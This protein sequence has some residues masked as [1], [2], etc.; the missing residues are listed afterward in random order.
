MYEKN[1]D[2][3]ITKTSDHAALK[4]KKKSMLYPLQNIV[5]FETFSNFKADN[6]LKNANLEKDVNS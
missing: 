1:V 3:I 2:N 6:L 4:S 5:L